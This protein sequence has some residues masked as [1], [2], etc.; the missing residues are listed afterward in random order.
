MSGLYHLAY[1]WH[2]VLVFIW[3]ALL[4]GFHAFTST[5]LVTL[6]WAE[7]LSYSTLMVIGG[8]GR[9][10]GGWGGAC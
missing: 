1:I 9:V 5:I 2:W 7:A 4:R 8:G 6:Y 3:T 10:V